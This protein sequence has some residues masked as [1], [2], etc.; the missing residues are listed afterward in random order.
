[1]VLLP[2]R[3][4][5]CFYGFRSHLLREKTSVNARAYLHFTSEHGLRQFVES[6]NGHTFITPKGNLCRSR[7]HL[8]CIAGKE[9]RAQIEPAPFQAVPK[10]KQKSDRYDNTIEN[11]MFHFNFALTLDQILI[12]YNSS[13]FFH[14]LRQVCLVPKN[15][16]TNELP[17]E[18]MVL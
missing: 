14:N 17:K 7:H 2:W 9:Q 15:N 8:T 1:L 18:K 6:F 13:K 12:T 11:G 16:L 3:S 10:S 4:Q 5:V